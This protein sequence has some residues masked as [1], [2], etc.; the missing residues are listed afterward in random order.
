LVDELRPNDNVET[1]GGDF[2][3][4]LAHALDRSD[5]VAGQHETARVRNNSRT[6]SSRR[7]TPG[8]QATK[9]FCVWHFGHAAGCGVVKPAMDADQLFAKAMIDQ[10]RIAVRTRKSGSRRRGTRFSGA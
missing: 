9:E 1:A 10:P 2:R 8:P 4:L 3:R 6:S 5:E 7:S